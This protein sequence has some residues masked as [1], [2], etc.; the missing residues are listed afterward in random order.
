MDDDRLVAGRYRLLARV[1]RGGM[2]T[3][4]RARD[5]LLNRDVAVKEVQLPADLDDARLQELRDRTLREARAAARITSDA[6]VAVFD[7]VEEDGRPWIVMELLEHRTLEHVRRDR[8]RLGVRET[9]EVGLAVLQALEAA[10]RAGVLH[11]DVK[12]GN[13]MLRQTGRGRSPYVLADF[14]IA[15]VS[16][17]PTLTSTGAVVGSPSYLAP[18][19]A[20]GEAASEASDLWSL[21]ATLWACVEGDPPFEREGVLPTLAAVA[22][23]E[24]PEPR[25][26][27]PL[28][29]LLAA[30]LVKDPA[31]RADLPTARRMLQEVLTG[32]TEGAAV[33]ATPD[34]PAPRTP[35]R[36]LGAVAAVA[37][38]LLVAGA[39][40]LAARPWEQGG[41]PSAAPTGEQPAATATGPGEPAP[42]EPAPT[43]PAP[44][45]PAAA[46]PE[47]TDDA[48]DG[49]D[50]AD[51]AGVPDGFTRYQDETGF[52]VAVPAGWQ[53]ER[54]GPR[55]YLRDPDSAA[56]LM[57]DQTDDPADDPLADWQRQEE[58]VSQRLEN[59]ER[60]RLEGTTFRGWD[61]ADWEFLHGDGQSTRVLNRNLVT[62]QD[63]A[64]ALYWSVPAGQWDERLPTFETAAG[65]FTPRS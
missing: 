45:E 55:V 12:P 25:H 63:Q 53:A 15:T 23:Q 44:T 40:L 42:T 26:A 11:R 52:S 31:A 34:E 5:E 61:G 37:A 24:L 2:G 20:R 21:G 62:A 30:L 49:A 38:L 36:R 58:P 32:E 19:R 65:S 27:G 3:V 10:H 8:G 50:G 51:G 29:P 56:Y 22:G 16:G 4:W 57:V 6:A 43:E 39:A 18:E 46:D 48:E 33:R 28:G 1:G 47:P 35:R 59:Y 60:L 64:Y 14:G 17:D 13:V 41:T 9:A 54:E 7:V